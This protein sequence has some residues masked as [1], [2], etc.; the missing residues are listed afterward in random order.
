MSQQWAGMTCGGAQV[1]WLSPILKNVSHD[2]VS[3]CGVCSAV[4]AAVSLARSDGTT[5]YTRNSIKLSQLGHTFWCE[6]MASMFLTHMRHE[7]TICM[8]GVRERV[9]GTLSTL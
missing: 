7:T 6:W 5:D 8:F 4:V 2:Y 3:G 1:A 9:R